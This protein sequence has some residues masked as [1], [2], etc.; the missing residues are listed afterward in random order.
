MDK[1]VETVS[2]F[3]VWMI[4]EKEEKS[5]IDVLMENEQI[6]FKD[7]LKHRAKQVEKY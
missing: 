4:D 5:I 2:V 3:A 7:Q 6:F 1:L